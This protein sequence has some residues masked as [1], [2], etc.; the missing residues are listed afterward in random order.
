MAHEP[1][2]RDEPVESPDAKETR[3]NEQARS[4]NDDAVRGREG[5]HDVDPDAAESE[6]NRD[7]TQVD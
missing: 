1:R 6:V 7:D 5:G 4:V 3:E 2:D